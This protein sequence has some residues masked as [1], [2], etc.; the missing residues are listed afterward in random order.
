MQRMPGCS[1]I[2]KSL[3][4]PS[5]RWPIRGMSGPISRASTGSSCPMS[6]ASPHIRRNATRS[7]PRVTKVFDWVYSRTNSGLRQIERPTGCRSRSAGQGDP[8]GL[9]RRH[10]AVRGLACLTT[11]KRCLREKTKPKPTIATRAWL[12]VAAQIHRSPNASAASP[13]LVR[14]GRV[15]RRCI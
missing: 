12:A 15:S 4:G 5:I 8:D 2:T 6:A 14:L 1:T 13:M 7:R 10:S 11:T 3:I 9:W